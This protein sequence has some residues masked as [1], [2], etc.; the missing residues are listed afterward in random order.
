MQMHGQKVFPSDKHNRSGFT[1]AAV[2]W[3]ERKG[4]NQINFV[5]EG[6]DPP[7]CHAEQALARRSIFAPIICL[8]GGKVAAGS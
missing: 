3:K 6:L 7:V 2:F 1:G 5:W 4:W 8:A